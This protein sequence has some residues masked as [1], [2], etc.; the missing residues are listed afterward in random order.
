MDAEALPEAEVV[1]LKRWIEQGAVW[2]EAVGTN[3][4]SKSAPQSGRAEEQ[5]ILSANARLFKEK[6]HPIL[7]SRCGTCHGDERK[8]SGFTLETRAGFLSGGWHGPVVVAGSPEKSRLYRRVARLEKTY[9]PLGITGGVGE[10]LPEAELAL[11]KEW[12]EGGAEWPLDPQAEEAERARQARLKD[13]AKLE[14]RPVT[15]EERRWWSFV[16]PVRPPVPAVKNVARVKN[17]IDAFVLAALESKGLQPAPRASRRT[18]IRRVYLDL[19]GLPPRPEDVQAFEDDAAP[20]AYEKLINRLLDSERYGE[21]WARHWLDVARYADSDGY[22]YDRIRP[23]AWRY[24]DYV[25]RALNQDKP[26]NRFILEQLAGD[27]LPDRSYDSLTALG[28]CRNGPFI[29][30]MVLMQNEMTRQDEL[31]DIVTTTSAAF[32]GVTM[33]CARCH[34]HKYDP[35]AQKDYYRMVSVFA[36]S[37][38]TNIPLAPAH[39]VEAYD[40][41]VFEIDQQVDKLTQQLHLLQ[42][43]TRDR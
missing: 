26:Y 39:L 16:T 24:R 10:P 32:L 19:I 36:P 11:I 25:I 42:K 21:R 33:G 43:P 17:P 7:S 3:T 8:Y 27:E 31:D 40:K 23:N 18:L 9:M 1:L 20:D 35:L 12:I 6:V 41:Q 29:G 28:F 4:Q 22:E 13:L 34:N 15:E 5:Q 38:R 37:V 2:P 30:D 14:N